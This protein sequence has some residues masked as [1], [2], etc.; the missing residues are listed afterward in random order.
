LDRLRELCEDLVEDCCQ[1]FGTVG[2]YG[3]HG[4]FGR[5]AVSSL[6]ATKVITGATGGW[7]WSADDAVVERISTYTDPLFRSGRWPRIVLTLSDVHAG[8]ARSQLSRLAQIRDRRGWITQRYLDVCPERLAPAGLP[9]PERMAYRFILRC[10]DEEE[11]ERLYEHFRQDG[12]DASR[13]IRSGELLHRELGMD[14]CSFPGAEDA[15]RRTLSLPLY[16]AM[17]DA[18][19]EQVAVALSR[20]PI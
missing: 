7:C 11:R 17:S 8:L 10:S 3:P 16:P 2:P 15:V 1:S 18:A 4:A 9:D 12:V 6:Y 13:L 19:V 14:P 20:V 5:V